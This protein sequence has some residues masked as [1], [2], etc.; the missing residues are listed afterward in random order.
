[1]ANKTNS[2]INGKDY[3]RIRA[4]VGKKPDG[5]RIRKSFYGKN[6]KRLNKSVTNTLIN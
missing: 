5:S 2:T 4:D 6:K 3:Y 1:M